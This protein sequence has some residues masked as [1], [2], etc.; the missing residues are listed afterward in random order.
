MLNYNYK[1]YSGRMRYWSQTL[2]ITKIQ[3]T[4]YPAFRSLCAPHA[5]MIGTQEKGWEN[6]HKN[7]TV[8]NF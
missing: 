1:I 5:G 8:E 7:R 3:N 6:P 2:N 4:I